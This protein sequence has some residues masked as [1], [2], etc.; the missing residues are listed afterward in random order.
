MRTAWL[1]RSSTIGMNS[2]LTLRS[3]LPRGSRSPEYTVHGPILFRL[4]MMVQLGQPSPPQTHWSCGEK[5]S[6]SVGTGTMPSLWAMISSNKGVTLS[7]SLSSTMMG[8]RWN[9]T[10]SMAILGMSDRRVLLR[11]FAMAGVEFLR[12]NLAFL[13][14]ISIIS[15]SMRVPPQ[16][17]RPLRPPFFLVP[18]CGM[19]VTSSMRPILSPAL[20]RA[21]MA[22]CAPGPGET[23]LFPPGAR[24][25]TWIPTKS[26]SLAASAT[27][28]A[29]F[30]AA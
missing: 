13:S 25:L 1:S 11:A 9:S 16:T 20:V 4:Y 8:P 24:T 17:L 6:R 5:S 28:S 12:M 15:M 30:W 10:L 2:S 26:F 21:R 29:A 22:A 3:G 27:F 18:S 23:D 19:G 7:Y 14:A